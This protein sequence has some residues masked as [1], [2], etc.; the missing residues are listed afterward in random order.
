[1]NPNSGNQRWSKWTFTIRPGGTKRPD[2]ATVKANAAR[3]GRKYFGAASAMKIDLSAGGIVT[4]QV[5]TEGHPVHDPA[6]VATTT[7]LWERWAIGGWG[8][9]T[10]LECQA[11]LEAGS[12]QDGRPVDQLILADAAALAIN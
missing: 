6:Y 4:I 5:R 12:Y 11:K 8:N 7:Q 1:M 3:V 2:F 10:R 9:G